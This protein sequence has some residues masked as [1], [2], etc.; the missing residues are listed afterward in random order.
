MQ[1]LTK[2]ESLCAEQTYVVAQRASF[3]TYQTRNT[4]SWAE[5]SMVHCLQVLDT[6][7]VGRLSF[8]QLCRSIRLLV[9]FP[10]LSIGAFDYTRQL[11]L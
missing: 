5:L 8:S 11:G 1:C 4:R 3:G 6:E 7:G 9:R 10:Y 2:L